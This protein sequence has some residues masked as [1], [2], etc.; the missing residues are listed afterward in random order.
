MK[1]RRNLYI[2]DNIWALS[3]QLAIFLSKNEDKKISQS[4]V[5][6]SGILKLKEQYYHDGL[7]EYM[8]EAPASKANLKITNMI[9]NDIKSHR[10]LYIEDSLWDRIERLSRQIAYEENQRIPTHEVI[11][12]AFKEFLEK[13]KA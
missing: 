3:K 10:S 13:Y 6:E 7:F 4:T 8:I 12:R 9:Q 2:D 5:F 11:R 1:S